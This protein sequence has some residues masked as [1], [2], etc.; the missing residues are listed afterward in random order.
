MFEENQNDDGNERRKNDILLIG[1]G[2]GI[3]PLYS[4]L[5]NNKEAFADGYCQDMKFGK[6]MLMY[7]SAT[8]DELIFKVFFLLHLKIC[9]QFNRFND[10]ITHTIHNITD[11]V[12]RETCS[13]LYN[14]KTGC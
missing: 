7:S 11:I 2:V 14:N 3:N 9:N 12:I 6:T 4:M 1:G 5:L 8:K 10:K 13:T